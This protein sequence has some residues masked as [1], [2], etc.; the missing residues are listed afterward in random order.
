M[1]SVKISIRRFILRELSPE[2]AT[3]RYLSWFEGDS[4]KKYSAK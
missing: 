3:V 1:N 2:D 4:V